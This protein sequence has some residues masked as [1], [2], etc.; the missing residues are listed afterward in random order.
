VFYHPHKKQH[1]W[2]HAIPLVIP[3]SPI[4]PLG[5]AL[6]LIFIFI[7][8]F[9]FFLVLLE[10]FQQCFRAIWINRKFSP[11]YYTSTVVKTSVAK[12]PVK[13]TSSQHDKRPTFLSTAGASASF[14]TTATAFVVATIS[15]SA[16]L[17]LDASVVSAALA[18]VAADC[19][20]AA[21]LTS[22]A[23]YCAAPKSPV[24]LSLIAQN[25]NQFILFIVYYLF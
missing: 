1:H 7:L 5:L 20:C 15:V 3:T 19:S 25:H 10:K 21:L 4:S 11:T 13:S 2:F 6:T 18:L 8:F 23:F 17:Y 14:G 16:A 9:L 12:P 22:L 24:A